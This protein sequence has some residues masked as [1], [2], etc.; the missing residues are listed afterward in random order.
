ILLQLSFQSLC[1]AGKMT[2]RTFRA[3]DDRLATV[4]GVHEGLP[5]HGVYDRCSA[6]GQPGRG[7]RCVAGGFPQGLRT[8]RRVEREPDGRR[9]AQDRDAQ[10]LLES[11]DTL[12][13][14][15]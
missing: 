6:P 7:R 11:P 12:P 4:R 1:S 5:E 13:G 8:L 14:A 3:N 2:L 9:L 15:L 10:P